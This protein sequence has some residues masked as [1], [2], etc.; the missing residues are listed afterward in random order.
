MSDIYQVEFKGAKRAYFAN[1][2]SIPL[3][4]GDYVLVQVERGEDIG[5]V[6]KKVVQVPPVE[7]T[8][9][10]VLCRASEEHMKTMEENA[11]MRRKILRDCLSKIRERKLNMKVVDVDYQFDG[12]K[13]TFYF[14][15]EKRIDFRGLVKDLATIY[16]ARIEFCQIGVRDEAR[17]TGG[18]GSCGR[19]LCCTTFIEEFEP[20][21]AQ[22]AKDQHLT[23]IPS[24]LSGV[25][26]RLMCCLLF[27]RELYQ[28]ELKKYPPMGSEIKTAKGAGTV[29]K[30]DIFKKRITVLHDNGEL[31]EISL[32]ELLR[33]K[34]RRRIFK[35]K[36]K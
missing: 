19:Q 29:E 27:E 10:P 35:R 9:P 4:V 12:K 26:G 11:Q 17:R 21:T 31:E 15:A 20:I 8:P 1:P 14:T 22:L 25:C 36:R 2:N 5:R 32:L 34:K 30:V 23:M 16:Q 6:I 13:I 24:K 33:Q 28:Q 7:G 3:R 18:Y